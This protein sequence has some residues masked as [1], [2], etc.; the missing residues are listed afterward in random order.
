L[1]LLDEAARGLHTVLADPELGGCVPCEGENPSLLL[2]G[3]LTPTQVRDAVH[4][5][6]RRAAADGGV[7]VL[8]LLGHGFAGP[9]LYYMVGRSQ[10]TDPTTAVDV[11][12]LLGDI[13]NITGL[14]GTIA[15]ID[16][17]HAGA[18]VPPADTLAQ[19]VRAGITR[20]AV[21]TATTAGKTARDMRFSRELTELIRGGTATEDDTLSVDETFVGRLR[22]KVTGQTVGFAVHDQDGYADGPLWL[23]RNAR[24]AAGGRVYGPLAVRLLN[25]ALSGRSPTPARWTP[26]YLTAV[27]ERLAGEDASDSLTQLTIQRL[28]ELQTCLNE[29]SRTAGFLNESLHAVLS[30]GRLRDA[31]R[32][33]KFPPAVA[34][35]PVLRDLLEHAVLRAQREDEAPWHALAWFVAALAHLEGL[36]LDGCPDL[37]AWSQRLGVVAPARTALEEYARD[38]RTTGV[39][40]VLGLDG[41]WGDWPDDLEGWLVRHGETVGTDTFRLASRDERGVGEAIGRALHWARGLLHSDERPLRHVDVAA[42]AAVLARW[43]PEEA[44]AGLKLLGAVCQVTSRWSGPIYPDGAMGDDRSEINDISARVIDCLEEG[45]PVDDALAWL[46]AARLAD[47]GRLQGHLM[48]TAVEAA[49]GA[50]RRTPDWADVLEV[51][52]PHAPVLLWPGEGVALTAEEIR[53]AVH[54]SWHG[55]PGALA[56]AHRKRLSASGEALPPLAYV[57]AVWHDRAWLDFCRPFE[58]RMVAAPV[59]VEAAAPV[60]AHA[61]TAADRPVAA[62]VDRPAATA[63]GTAPGGPTPGGTPATAPVGAPIAAQ[64][65]QAAQA[66]A[67]QEEP[68]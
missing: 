63:V 62:V 5:A 53:E 1:K 26:A 51:L 20:L 46:D 42:S 11:R 9:H 23:T 49:L 13:A 58:Q 61:A 36:S 65:P 54:S 21:L 43:H 48:T 66:A 4:E 2:G 27:L 15:L 57:R 3:D 30:D 24:G 17:C 14:D 52:M 40:L 22:Q 67:P 7:L 10:R 16:T 41:S 50:D 12:S 59:P 29:C 55:L 31:A 47:P 8:A 64:A 35:T 34:D 32:L 45:R 38:R 44:V 18:A 37:L 6:A 28:T 33:A 68:S 56:D 60:A 25:E 39:R 19:G